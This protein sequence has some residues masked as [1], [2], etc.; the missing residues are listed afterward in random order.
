MLRIA[1]CDDEAIICKQIKKFIE[2]YTSDYCE[3]IQI[4]IF[5]NGENLYD[6]LDSLQYFDLIFIDIELYKI[7]GIEIASFIRNDL[8]NQSSQ[9]VFISSKKKYALDLFAVRPLDFLLKPISEE[10]IKNSINLTKKLK[11]KGQE[12]FSY[13]SSNF[14]R[15][16]PL[17]DIY[18]FE[19]NARKIK[20]VYEKGEDIFYGKLDEINETVQDYPFLRIHQSFLV[21]YVKVVSSHLSEVILDNGMTLPVSRQKRKELLHRLAEIKTGV[22]LSWK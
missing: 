14:I 21:N 9:I 2:T 17:A 6:C 3:S 22:L 4:N 12:V 7:S 11:Q 18:F 8:N 13:K 15:N 1:I 19:S 16:I 5:E 10:S 20:I